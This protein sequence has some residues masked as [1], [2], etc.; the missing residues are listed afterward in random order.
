MA[1]KRS[2]SNSSGDCNASSDTSRKRSEQLFS[3]QD[4]LLDDQLDSDTEAIYDPMVLISYYL[5]TRAVRLP[6]L[7][8]VH[9]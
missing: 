9:V 6:S 5:F 2:T 7:A 3:D 4:N 8:L 1:L